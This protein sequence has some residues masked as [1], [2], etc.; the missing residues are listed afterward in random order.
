[1]NRKIIVLSLC[2]LFTIGLKAMTKWTYSLDE[3]KKMAIATN[4]LILVDFW[5]TWCGPCKRMD[6]ESWDNDE[7]AS[8]ADSYIPVRIDIDIYREISQNYSVKA[9]PFVFILDANGEII[10]QKIGYQDRMQ[11]AKTLKKFALNTSYLQRDLSMYYKKQ[12]SISSFRLAQKYQNF[13]IYLNDDVRGSILSMAAIYF[14][15][16]EHFLKA[17]KKKNV[18]IEQ[19]IKLCEVQAVLIRNNYKRSLKFLKKKFKENTIE[20]TN[21]KLYYF[22][23]FVASKG[24][25]EAQTDSWLAKLKTTDNYKVYLKRADK[26]LNHA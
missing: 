16:T 2:L 3:A 7:I 18:A 20:Q 21:K 9:I 19:K 10:Y 5:A 12:N 15:K 23:Y 1:M 17:E 22:L 14:N 13:A 25:N 24:L 4:K 6:S 26:I 8:L 11:L